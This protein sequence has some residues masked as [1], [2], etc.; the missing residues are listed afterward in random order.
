MSDTNPLMKANELADKT[1]VENATKLINLLGVKSRKEQPSL[2]QEG[3]GAYNASL[4][5]NSENKW[6]EAIKLDEIN[7]TN[8]ITEWTPLKT[9][10][11]SV[12]P[13]K[14]EYVLLFTEPELECRG[15]HKIS[16]D[17][18]DNGSSLLLHLEL[19]SE[20]IQPIKLSDLL[21]N[22][23]LSDELK[24]ALMNE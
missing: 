10:F 2:I 8:G 21:A 5:I 1:I 15:I 13:Q 3:T 18:T 23:W 4:A 16:A 12:L 24:T 19:E 7:N 20:F 11:N 14:D 9:K 22:Q 17:V 6:I